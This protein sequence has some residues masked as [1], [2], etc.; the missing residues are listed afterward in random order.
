[1]G[2]GLPPVKDRA[3]RICRKGEEGKHMKL[4][5]SDRKILAASIAAG[6]AMVL[7][8][9]LRSTAMTTLD[10]LPYEPPLAAW[11]AGEGHQE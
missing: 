7:C 9:A 4:S 1:M 2:K 5:R 10:S 11:A 6:A 8:F 3:V